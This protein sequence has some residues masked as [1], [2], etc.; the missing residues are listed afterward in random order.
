M[1]CVAAL[2]RP[3]S[4]DGHKTVEIIAHADGGTVQIYVDPTTYLPVREVN[5]PAGDG[6]RSLDHHRRQ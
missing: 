5:I 6:E 3:A 2:V 1:V 4:V